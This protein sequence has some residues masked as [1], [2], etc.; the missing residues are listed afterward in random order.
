MQFSE[1]GNIIGR[2]QTKLFQRFAKGLESIRQL[3][4]A[5]EFDDM[6]TL[7]KIYELNREKL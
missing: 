3:F 6:D 7:L 1:H 4:D 2:I 5:Y